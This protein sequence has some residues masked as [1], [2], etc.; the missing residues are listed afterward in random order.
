MLGQPSTNRRSGRED[1]HRD[2]DSGVPILL[3]GHDRRDPQLDIERAK[4][5]LHIP[6]NRFDLDDQEDPQ[7][8]EVREEIDAPPIPVMVEADLHADQPAPSLKTSFQVL[9]D[10]GVAGIDEEAGIAGSAAERQG[11]PRTEGVDERADGVELE[12][13]ES[14][15][16]EAHEG[17]ARSASTRGQVDLAPS[18]PMSQAPHRS[19]D[20][21]VAHGRFDGGASVLTRRLRDDFLARHR[22]KRFAM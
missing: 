22:T 20:L 14:P 8:R 18:S 9:L 2:D 19:P 10:E 7:R 16:L 15:R 11:H 17:R 21:L 3:A 5:R 4:K 12:I 13:T 6:E 1:D